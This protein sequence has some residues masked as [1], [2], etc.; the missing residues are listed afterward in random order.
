MQNEGIVGLFKGNL[1]NIYKS[2]PN[3]CIKF[4]LNEFYLRKIIKNENAS[5][6]KELNFNQLFYCGLLT[7]TV[8]TSI[9]YP[10]DLVRT[11]IM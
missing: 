6:I 8:Q 4:P 1:A 2:I 9:T 7:G 10:I 3:Y 5:S 11:R